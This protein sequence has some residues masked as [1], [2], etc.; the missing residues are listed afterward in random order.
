MA[1]QTAGLNEAADG[2]AGVAGFASL[3][4]AD[5]DPAGAN[6]V[7]GGSP[8]YARQAIT[9]DP[10]SGAVAGLNGTLAF[11]GPASGAA[12]HLGIWSAASGGTYYGSAALTGDQAFNASGEYN[13]TDIT[14]TASS[15]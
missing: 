1:V 6:E 3:H 2:L 9:W 4:T 7:T 10:A 11:N 14:I 12:T 5:P 8:A 13:V 15:S